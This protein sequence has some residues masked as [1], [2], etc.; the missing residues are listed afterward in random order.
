[1][2]YFN[3]SFHEQAHW[4][5]IKGFLFIFITAASLYL[6]LLYNRKLL[7]KTELKFKTLFNTHPQAMLIFNEKTGLFLEVNIAAIKK[8]GYSKEEFS[9][10][11][12]EDIVVESTPVST[13]FEKTDKEDIN[14]SK[15]R[16][17]NGDCFYVK[18]YCH[19]TYFDDEQAVYAVLIDVHAEIE[20]YQK[21]REVSWLQ[22]HV[23]RR[24]LA[25]I[26]GLVEL[27]QLKNQHVISD[28]EDIY[29]MLKA[30]ATELDAIVK[31]I[32]VKANIGS[33]G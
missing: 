2:A 19:K 23:L 22:S 4:Q 32:V 9:Q 14:I 26:L 5:T 16:N 20:A 13:F 29:Q 17:K 33:K 1:M 8:Y 27:L 10:M 6:L 3:I 11:K 30:S 28:D 21:L 18:T 15:H 31:E 7:S 12:L 24:P 25:N